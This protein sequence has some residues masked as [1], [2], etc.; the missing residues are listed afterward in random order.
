MLSFNWALT[1]FITALTLVTGTQGD[2]I[3]GPGATYPAWPR[4]VL[5][6]YYTGPPPQPISIPTRPF[7]W[8]S[9]SRDD[10]KQIVSGPL[11]GLGGGKYSGVKG[12]NAYDGITLTFSVARSGGRNAITFVSAETEAVSNNDP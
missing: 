10:L 11:K 12:I 1:T 8:R 3:P 5:C 6:R 7:E 9:F 4:D 2:L